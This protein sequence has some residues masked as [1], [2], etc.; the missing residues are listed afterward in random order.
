MQTAATGPVRS[1]RTDDPALRCSVLA[2]GSLEPMNLT[3]LP[4]A[5]A[6]LNRPDQLEVI[7]AMTVES[8][9]SGLF[10]RRL[11]PGGGG[12]QL[13]DFQFIDQEGVDHGRLEVTTTTRMAR[14]GFG[15]EV[16]KL[17]WQFP[18]LSWSWIVNAKDSA[19]VKVIHREIEA[20]L[21]QLEADCRT[22]RWIPDHPGLDATD[23]EALPAAL[24]DIG[25]ISVCAYHHHSTGETSWVT[26]SPHIR[27]GAFSLDA[28][29]SEAQAE[30]DKLDNQHKLQSFDGDGHFQLFIWLDVGDG[31]AALFSFR[32]QPF[33][34]MVTRLPRLKLPPGMTT[35]WV[36]SG[37]AAWPQPVSSLLIADQTGW[38]SVSAPILDLRDGQLSQILARL[39][40]IA[41]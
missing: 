19:R 29:V 32:E 18:S 24:V 20:S 14:S 34:E 16:A 2:A 38:R 11:D 4:A 5:L 1:L 26:V 35:V 15:R 10:L 3:G 13:A 8:L 40:R 6:K 28:V 23:P 33:N 27:G 12:E 9:A 36:A 41:L 39:C 31:Q 17:D 22:D 7:A 21:S 37:L 30:V 25:I